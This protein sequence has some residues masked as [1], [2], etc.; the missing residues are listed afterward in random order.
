MFIKLDGRV[1][2]GVNNLKLTQRL[3]A[4][5]RAGKFK[6]VVSDAGFGRGERQAV[7]SDVHL[8]CFVKPCEQPGRQL[9]ASQPPRNCRLLVK[10]TVF[11]DA[12]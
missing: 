7:K 12:A 5:Q 11:V 6:G 8:Q 4:G 3:Q 1:G 10:F 9:S 2:R